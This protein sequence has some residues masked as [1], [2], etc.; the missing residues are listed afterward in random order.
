MELNIAQKGNNEIYFPHI[1][2]HG[3]PLHALICYMNSELK[4][5]NMGVIKSIEISRDSETF[6]QLM[7]K[8]TNPY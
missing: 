2:L 6:A 5:R 7:K 3:N 4:I 8:W 1:H